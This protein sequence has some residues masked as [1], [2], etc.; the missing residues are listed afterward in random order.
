MPLYWARKS[1][2][3]T[4]SIHTTIR[5]LVHAFSTDVI[6]AKKIKSQRCA[7]CRNTP[8]LCVG[9]MSRSISIYIL[10]ENG[11]LY[12][13]VALQHLF[14]IFVTSTKYALHYSC[15]FT[16]IFCIKKV[17]W[18]PTRGKWIIDPNPIHTRDGFKSHTY[19]TP[20]YLL[21]RYIKTL[22]LHDPH[23]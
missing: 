16:D 9:I 19:T 8:R 1:E 13:T 3:H 17:Q 20:Q 5:T 7:S 6:E 15:L 23:Y 10:S 4:I 21:T 22:Y 14:A 11:T 18:P 12:S 2:S